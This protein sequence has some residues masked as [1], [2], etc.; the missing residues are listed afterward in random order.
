MLYQLGQ[1]PTPPP[2]NSFGEGMEL[3]KYA[4]YAIAAAFFWTALQGSKK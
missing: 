1:T 2:Q 3:M 4:A